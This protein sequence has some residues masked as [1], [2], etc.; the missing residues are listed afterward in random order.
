MS[1]LNT[2]LLPDPCVTCGDR[3]PSVEPWNDGDGHRG[4]SVLCRGCEFIPRPRSTERAAAAYWNRLNGLRRVMRQRRA[5]TVTRK[6]TK[7]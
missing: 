6:G 1:R 3:T 2:P 7:S 5:T 4:F